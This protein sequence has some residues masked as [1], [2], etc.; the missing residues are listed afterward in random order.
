MNTALVKSVPV[1]DFVEVSA[2]T[3]GWEA[4]LKTLV[5]EHRPIRYDTYPL[6]QIPQEIEVCLEKSGYRDLI[7]EKDR[8]QH[9]FVPDL[10]DSR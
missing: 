5:S 10:K 7:L 3:K 9:F 8:W 1:G 6:E 2:L 4:R